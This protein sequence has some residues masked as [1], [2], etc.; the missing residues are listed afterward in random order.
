MLRYET[1]AVEMNLGTK[2]QRM[3]QFISDLPIAPSSDSCFIHFT[4]RIKTLRISIIHAGLK[5]GRSVPRRVAAVELA[6]PP[7]AV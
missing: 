6:V 4:P 1:E 3:A 7:P 2:K 5:Q